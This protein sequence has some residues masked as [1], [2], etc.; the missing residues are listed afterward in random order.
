M[1]SKI[2]VQLAL[3]GG[4]PVR[5]DPFPQSP[6]FGDEEIQAAVEAGHTYVLGA[7]TTMTMRGTPATLAGTAFMSTDEG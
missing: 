3:F 7:G 5:K 1:S 6:A 4:E 2:G